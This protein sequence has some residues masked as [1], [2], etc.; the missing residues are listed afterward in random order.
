MECWVIDTP[1]FKR[2]LP[3]PSPGIS[4]PSG[5]PR[6]AIVISQEAQSSGWF[7]RVNCA[8]TADTDTVTLESGLG[9]LRIPDWPLHFAP[10]AITPATP[11]LAVALVLSERGGL[12][13]QKPPSPSPPRTASPS[14]SDTLAERALSPQMQ[15]VKVG[16]VNGTVWLETHRS[17]KDADVVVLEDGLVVLQ[18]GFLLLD[19]SSLDIHVELL[20]P[21]YR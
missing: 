7:R 11:F 21:I 19:L 9:S 16:Y 8:G 18:P 17:P 5:I 2:E 4:K 12:F 15:Q 10:G 3:T 13:Q 14:T 6:Q 20:V 1:F